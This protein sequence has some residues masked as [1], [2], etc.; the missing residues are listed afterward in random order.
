MHVGIG[1]LCTEGGSGTSATIVEVLVDTAGAGPK[2]SRMLD[3]PE[4]LGGFGSAFGFLGFLTKKAS[5]EVCTR[6]GLLVME[7][8][9]AGSVPLDV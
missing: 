3:W 4:V 1:L 7:E 5:M 8:A 6:K 2:K 9:C